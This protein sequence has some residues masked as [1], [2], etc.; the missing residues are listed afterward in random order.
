MVVINAFAVRFNAFGNYFRA[1]Q[2]IHGFFVSSPTQMSSYSG[3]VRL[4]KLFCFQV[5]ILSKKYSR[6]FEQEEL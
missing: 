3:D 1:D 5:K 2:Y 6:V 4:R